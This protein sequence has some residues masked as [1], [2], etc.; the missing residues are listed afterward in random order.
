MFAAS[1]GR[2]ERAYVRCE[3][4]V[5]EESC[6]TRMVMKEVRDAIARILDGTTLADVQ[7]RVAKAGRAAGLNVVAYSI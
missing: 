2:S 4:C 6:G 3:E 1:L 5:S 7:Q